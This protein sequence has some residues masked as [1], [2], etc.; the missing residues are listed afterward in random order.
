MSKSSQGFWKAA[1][2]NVP[3]LP[4]RP[5]D[6]SPPAYANL[7]FDPH[8][9]GCLKKTPANEPLWGLRKRFCKSCEKEY[10]TER[11]FAMGYDSRTGLYPC[12]FALV[13]S[14]SGHDTYLVLN[15]DVAL[16]NERLKR[17]SKEEK[18]VFL[19]EKRKETK[20]RDAHA[21]LCGIWYATMKREREVEVQTVKDERYAAIIAKLKENGWA[22]EVDYMEQLPV[23]RGHPFQAVGA[24]KVARP[25]TERAWPKLYQELLPILQGQ[26]QARIRHERKL[27][28]IHRLEV[29]KQVFRRV[30]FRP[31]HGLQLFN[32]LAEIPAVKE[33]LLS[34]TDVAVTEESFTDHIAALPDYIAICFEK[35]RRLL[36]EHMR[37]ELDIPADVDPFS[38]PVGTYFPRRVSDDTGRSEDET[39]ETDTLE[40]LLSRLPGR[41]RD[42]CYCS[43]PTSKYLFCCSPRCNDVDPD[44]IYH[45]ILSCTFQRERW[46]PHQV[47]QHG[48]LPAFIQKLVKYCG[49]DPR[50]TTAEELDL[51]DVRFQCGICNTDEVANVMTWRA[52]VGH[53]FKCR[54]TFK[55]E[56]EKKRSPLQ[57]CDNIEGG[58]DHNHTDGSQPFLTI[59]RGSSQRVKD[60]V[61]AMEKRIERRAR[62]RAKNRKV[63]RCNHCNVFPFHKLVGRSTVE[64]HLTSNLCRH[65]IKD[66]KESDL[67]PVWESTRAWDCYAPIWLIPENKSVESLSSRSREVL[68]KMNADERVV[69]APLSDILLQVEWAC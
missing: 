53:M 52:A 12:P 55:S 59:W 45:M 57:W 13:T 31:L 7:M 58:A 54:E 1:M 27:V 56:D 5:L 65:S 64:G 30:N 17:M 18:D 19:K 38:L 11:Q 26:R 14:K 8:C 28:I 40:T 33:L 51:V 2:E 39:P 10:T 36:A 20:E 3:D 21:K 32:D 68:A 25:L 61:F 63:W 9:D 50:R 62:D 43:D 35:R 15:S 29:F 4:P 37:K 6:M 66:P 46:S 60:A 16:Y 67:S 48:W 23:K 22:E 41:Y 42:Y 49:K 44:E 24:I 69:K 47:L 34:P